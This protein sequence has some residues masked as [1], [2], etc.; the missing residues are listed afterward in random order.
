MSELLLQPS[1][2]SL[3]VE[4][5]VQSFE[6]VRVGSLDILNGIE[7]SGVPI[8]N[9]EAVAGSLDVLRGEFGIEDSVFESPKTALVL[10]AVA[11][12][13][14]RGEQAEPISVGRKTSE[15]EYVA[16][17]V[18]FVAGAQTKFGDQYENI[19]KEQS[20]SDVQSK[21]AYDRF[22]QPEVSKDMDEFIRG[23]KFDELR[24]RL[25]V[26]SET[27]YE[28]RVLAIDSE[29]GSQSFGL[30]PRLELPDGATP[31]QLRNYQKESD[32]RQ[33]Y[34]K[35]LQKNG[36]DF[37]EA[38]GREGA[39]AP[40]WV[41]NFEDGTQYLCLAL[42][43]AE[44]VMY[45]EEERANYYDDDSRMRD[46]AIVEHEYTHTQKQLL[47]KNKIGV[48]IALEEMRAEHF[49]GN[50]QGY[51]D[52]KKYFTGI[53]MLTGY[54]PTDSFEIDGSPYDEQT[55]L[56]DIAKNIGLDGLLDCLTTIPVNY[57]EDEGATSFLKSVVAHN[58]GS[59]SGQFQK[60]YDYYNSKLGKDVVTT[61]IDKFIDAAHNK[62]KGSG[63][64]TVE[65]WLSYGGNK[66]L[67]KIGRENFRRRYPE[68]SDNYDYDK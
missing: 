26:T 42:P 7:A 28:V 56:T 52:I 39:F 47:F 25:G 3:P 53:R 8:E 19:T 49:S 65:S 6:Q 20:V 32:Y 33:N 58:G 23:P 44:K 55:F 2:N 68:E 36:D 51:V 50:K 41:T 67:A 48:G 16:D 66:S 62:I 54:S 22:T 1:P 30:V 5:A 31:E 60:A 13:L 40:A 21:A 10:T 57:A 17:L 24:K 38:L 29:A 45:S 35:G 63:V 9:K 18:M 15:L 46:L 12:R 37:N 59:V 61:N 4:G 64:I 43:T 34:I 11:D 27:P 14:N